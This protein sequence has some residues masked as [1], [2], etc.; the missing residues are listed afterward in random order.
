MKTAI[1]SALVMFGVAIVISMCVAA[2]M[3]VIFLTIRRINTS[4]KG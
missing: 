1:I 4:K 2:L 3:K